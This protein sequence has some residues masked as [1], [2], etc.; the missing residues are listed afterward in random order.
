MPRTATASIVL[1]LVAV[2]L[3]LLVRATAPAGDE[4]LRAFLV[5][6]DSPLFDGLDLIFDVRAWTVLVALAAAAIA[7]RRSAVFGMIIVGADL[8]AE[9]T[10]FLLKEIINRARPISDLADL[11]PTASYPSGHV[12]RGV[13]GLG[14]L[15]LVLICMNP[16]LRGVLWTPFAVILV[17]LGIARVASGQHW[18]TD[19]VGGYLL[20]AAVLSA[21]AFFVK[22]YGETIA[23]AR[24]L[25]LPRSHREDD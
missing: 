11:V 13:A 7:W 2:V 6:H 5:E 19:V 8:A 21:A 24:T 1:C 4:A 3:G 16:G 14:A 10:A 25:T 9:G 15:A 18:P 20:G 23:G 22:P 17:L 12:T